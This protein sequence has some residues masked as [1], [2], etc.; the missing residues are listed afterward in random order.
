MNPIPPHKPKPGVIYSTEKHGMVLKDGTHCM[1]KSRRMPD[2][3]W[4]F[5]LARISDDKFLSEIFNDQTTFCRWLKETHGIL[6]NPQEPEVV[7]NN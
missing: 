4:Q 3:S 1:P 7:A 6:F 2:G 5:V